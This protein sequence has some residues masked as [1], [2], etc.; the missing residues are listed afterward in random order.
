MLC[1]SAGETYKLSHSQAVL[2]DLQWLT[3]WKCIDFNVAVFFI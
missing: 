3:I 2:C 1:T